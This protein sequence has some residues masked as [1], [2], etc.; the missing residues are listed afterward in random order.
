MYA[1]ALCVFSSD[2]RQ[3]KILIPLEL[4]LQMAVS[5][6][7]WVLGIQSGPCEARFAIQY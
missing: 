3:Q 6:L 4:E 2:D 1:C 7:P 5:H